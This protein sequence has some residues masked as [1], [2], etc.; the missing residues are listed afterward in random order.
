MFVIFKKVF[1]TLTLNLALFLI[2]ILGIQNSST[3]KKVKFI[4]GETVSLPVGCIL[5]I[6]FITGSAYGNLLNLN[7][8]NKKE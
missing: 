5:G 4:L 1:F 6:S 7:L 8:R 2:L 3:S